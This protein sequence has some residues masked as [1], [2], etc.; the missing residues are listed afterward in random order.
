MDIDGPSGINQQKQTPEDKAEQMIRESEENR[1][2][3]YG[4]PGNLSNNPL[5]VHQSN[6][7]HSAMVDEAFMIVVSHLDEATINKIKQGMLISQNFYQ[8]IGSR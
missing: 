1:V 6:Y 2:K 4:T 5:I 7:M 8:K 3:V